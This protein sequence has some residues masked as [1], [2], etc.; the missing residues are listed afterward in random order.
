[1][2]HLR[3]VPPGQRGMEYSFANS[4]GRA[5][6]CDGK[7]FMRQAILAF[8]LAAIAL[9]RVA[10]AYIVT[11]PTVSTF[12]DQY[13]VGGMATLDLDGDGNPDVEVFAFIQPPP[14]GTPDAGFGATGPSLGFTGVVYEGWQIDGG[15]EFIWGGH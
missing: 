15:Q 4:C 5:V 8:A 11:G 7:V 1:M 14:F 2:L 12:Q 6:H 10:R 3:H 9:P 13:G